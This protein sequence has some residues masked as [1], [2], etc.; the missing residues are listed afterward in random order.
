MTALDRLKIADDT[1][2]IFSSDNGG[3][4]D[5]GYQDGAPEAYKDRSPNF[6]LRGFKGSLWEGGMREPFIVRWPAKVKA[7]QTSGALVCLVDLSATLCAIAGKELPKGTC[8]DSFN[9][10]PELLG[11]PALKP[12]RDFL[13]VHAGGPKGA[14]AIRKGPWKLIPPAAGAGR[15]GAGRAGNA[16]RAADGPATRPAAGGGYGAGPIA[17]PQLFN[18]AED[19]GETKNVAAD[20]PEIVKELTELLN[21]ART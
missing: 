6:P 16:N 19:I 14:V 1:L 11:Y 20:H 8:P 21:K 13:V 18:L 17:V 4:I 12:S 7:G 5:D 10:M 9:V 2:I 3:V 15:G